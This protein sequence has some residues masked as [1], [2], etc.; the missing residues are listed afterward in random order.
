[1]RPY[2]EGPP[3]QLGWANSKAYHRTVDEFE[4]ERQ[5]ERRVPSQMRLPVYVRKELLVLFGH[6]REEIKQC[7]RNAVAIQKQRRQTIATYQT[8]PNLE[9]NLERLTK[10]FSSLLR[11]KRNH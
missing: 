3:I 7:T 5:A 1:M 10:A 4:N 8:C 6:S 2:S 9:E 11:R